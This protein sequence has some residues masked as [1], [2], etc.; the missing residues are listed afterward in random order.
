MTCR[1]EDKAA[2]TL[3]SWRCCCRGDCRKVDKVLDEVSVKVSV[4]VLD[5][6]GADVLL[7]EVTGADVLSLEE[8]RVKSDV[9]NMMTWLMR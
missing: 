8:A 7:L 2:A 1:N 3:A 6:A 4:K 9:R 5:G